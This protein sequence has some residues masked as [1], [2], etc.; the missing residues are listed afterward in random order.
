MSGPQFIR[1]QSTGLS[2]LGEML[3]SY[4][5]LQPKLTRSSSRDETANVN[6]LFYD[7]IVHALQNNN[8]YGSIAEVCYHAKIHC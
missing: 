5:K 6:E 8:I 2:G 1:P 4:Y 3:E 7:D